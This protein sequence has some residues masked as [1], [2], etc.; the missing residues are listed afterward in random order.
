MDKFE[1]GVEFETPVDAAPV[2]AVVVTI[3]AVCCG[4]EFEDGATVTTFCVEL[5]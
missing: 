1:L 3:D 2:A 4:L 5:E